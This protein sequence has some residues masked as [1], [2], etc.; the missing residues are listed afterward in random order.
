VILAG[1]VGGTNSRLALFRPDE[2]QPVRLEIYIYP[3][4]DH[5][6]L[7]EIAAAFLAGERVDAVR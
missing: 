5:G 6:G 1:D 2:T 3:S 7:E 4:G